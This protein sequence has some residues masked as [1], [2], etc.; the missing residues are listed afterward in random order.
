MKS[1]DS[2]NYVETFQPTPESGVRTLAP[3]PEDL[4]NVKRMLK[5]DVETSSK[6]LNPPPK[7]G[8]KTLAPTP[9]NLS[10]RLMKESI[11][12]TDFTGI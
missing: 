7:A 5:E 9:E 10:K 8:V 6:T 1:I 12:T 3:T 2:I 4:K 11:D